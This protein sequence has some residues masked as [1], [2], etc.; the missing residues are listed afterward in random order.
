MGGCQKIYIFNKIKSSALVF[1]TR[2]RRV[3]RGAYL[4][5]RSLTLYATSGAPGGQG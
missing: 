2:R 1:V 4:A 5:P 3:G